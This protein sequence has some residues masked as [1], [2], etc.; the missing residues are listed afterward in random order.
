MVES[1][2]VYLDQR[3]KNKIVNIQNFAVEFNHDW[4]TYNV[5][6]Q[7]TKVLRNSVTYFFRLF[8]ALYIPSILE[9]DIPWP[10]NSL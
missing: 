2:I 1:G 5:V 10:A 8:H 6:S 9:N 3:F 4:G 7:T